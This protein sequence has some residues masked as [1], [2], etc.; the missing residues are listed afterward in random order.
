M[1][2]WLF[3]ALLLLTQPASAQQTC[4]SLPAARGA[5]DRGWSAYRANDIAIAER[6]FRQALSLCPN[7]P[8]ALTGAGYVAMRQGRLVAARN[9]FARAVARDSASYDAI[10]GAGMS[11][12][13]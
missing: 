4:R 7:E 10:A 6:E 2:P 9:L 3:S 12:Y 8:G 1:S 5:I 11:A 13:R